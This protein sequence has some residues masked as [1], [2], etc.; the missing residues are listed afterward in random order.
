MDKATALLSLQNL[1][2]LESSRGALTADDEKIFTDAINSQSAADA[3]KVLKLYQGDKAKSSLST[4]DK[5]QLSEAV[6]A[7]GA[8]SGKKK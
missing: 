1:Y 7:L 6:A 4:H 5:T 3:G 8:K 2:K